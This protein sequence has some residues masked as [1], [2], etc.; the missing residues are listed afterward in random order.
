MIDS[1][2]PPKTVYLAGPEVFMPA[3]ADVVARKIALCRQYGFEPLSPS[4]DQVNQR[5]GLLQGPNPNPPHPETVS[6]I[7]I[8]IYEANVARMRACDFGICDLTPFRGPSADI[9]T[10]FELGLMTGMGKPVFGYSNV[11]S[12][13]LDRI[14]LR[15]LTDLHG[16]PN[17]LPTPI[18]ND[19]NGWVIEN[20]G[21]ADNLMVDSALAVGAGAMV[22][23]DVAL[24]ERFTDLGAFEACLQQAQQ[25]FGMAVGATP[26]A[27]PTKTGS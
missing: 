26:P 11:V 22:R 4:D 15:Q 17:P 13:Y 9:G 18:W 21:N 7:S 8:I 5:K 6:L 2:A 10:V 27:A 19:E 12:Q 14:S 16:R 1:P 25:H 24:T 3:Y 20:F 23:R